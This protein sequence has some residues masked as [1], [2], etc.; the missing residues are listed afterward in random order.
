M[1][2]VTPG[3]S[4]DSGTLTG[5]STHSDSDHSTPL[6]VS[7]NIMRHLD[8]NDPV[9][10]RASRVRRPGARSFNLASR[11]AGCTIP[12][13]STGLLTLAAV[14][15]LGAGAQ[16]S[17]P[18]PETVVGAHI[19]SRVNGSE[20]V[21]DDRPKRTRSDTGVTLHAVIETRRGTARIFYSDAGSTIR[22][23]GRKRAA[24][25]LDRAP[26]A[27][28]R[29]FKIEPTVDTMSNEAS[30]SFRFESIEYRDVPVRE[31][32]GRGTVAADVKPT[33]TPYRGSSAFEHGIGTMRYKLVAD[34]AAGE[35][36][37][38]GIEARRG[39]GSGGLSHRVH[40]VSL[41][42]D[43][44]FLGMM[45]ELYGQPYIWAS[46]GV[47]DRKHQSEHLEGSDCADLM[48]YGARRLG[49]PVS[50]TW[51]GGLSTYARVLHKGTLRDDGVYI[52]KRGAPIPFSAVGDLILFPRHVGAL[53]E[54]RGVPGVL[55]SSDIMMHTLF[56]SP[57]E[58]AIG[59]TSYGQMDIEI[60]RWKKR[61]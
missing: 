54:D 52:D 10:R 47:T 11:I 3:K 58:Q 45:T 9:S 22:V 1:T 55:D 53:A 56:A 37:S 49:Y 38:P 24:L 20:T 43:D 48:V 42:R 14:L 6:T 4:S 44:T 21:A 41:R 26:R 18:G 33:L 51:T 5:T 13:R 40:R 31:W 39:R 17:G 19:V 34:T 12:G 25:P 50:Y 61:R 8:S 27:A 46:G 2:R 36:S 60:L 16:A 28:L 7:L 35:L 15:A 23:A 32:A 59:D 57:R 30:G 29:W